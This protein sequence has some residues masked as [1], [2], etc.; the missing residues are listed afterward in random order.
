MVWSITKRSAAFRSLHLTDAATA[1]QRMTAL[2]TV[3]SDSETLASR[4]GMF[5]VAALGIFGSSHYVV[6][7]GLSAT[8]KLT[9]S[10]CRQW[11]IDEA[12]ASTGRQEEAQ[13]ERSRDIAA[14][15]PAIPACGRCRRGGC[16]A[17][18][19]SRRAW[20]RGAGIRLWL[21]V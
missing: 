1:S 4:R 12:A 21:R 14:T 17:P 5:G 8:R 13:S 3:E 11:C 15:H 20:V 9:D 10:R 6:A 19:R 7:P 16:P 18:E 2:G